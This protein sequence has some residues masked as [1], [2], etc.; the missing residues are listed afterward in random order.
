RS[1]VW[2][3][4]LIVSQIIS[5]QCIFYGLL[6]FWIC[7]MD[8]IAGADKSLDQMFKYQE[9]Q[10]KGLSGRLLVG[11]YALNALTCALGLWYIVKRTKQCLDFTATV[12]FFH[13]LICW[14]Y[15]LAFP[16]TLTWW[17]VNLIC[18]A[19]MTVVGEYLC[20]RTEMKAIPLSLGVKTDL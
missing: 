11:A 12:H 20:M 16:Q 2:D 9:L 10:F 15:N 7:I 17:L 6:G 3:P 14:C 18:V 5:M 4:T 8:F 1:F 19:I 13:L